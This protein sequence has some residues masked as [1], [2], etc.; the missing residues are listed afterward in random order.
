MK[1]RPSIKQDIQ[2]KSTKV[3]GIAWFKPQQWD[4]LL[5]ISADRDELETTY[6]EWKNFVEKSVREMQKIGIRIKK[7]VI[8]TEKLLLWCNRHKRKVDAEARSLY[9]AD[10]LRKLSKKK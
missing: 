4:R 6:E 3:L 7:I 5:Q 8:D 10:I 1:K 9:V 2:S